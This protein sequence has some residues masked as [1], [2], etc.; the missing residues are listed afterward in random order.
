MKNPEVELRKQLLVS[1]GVLSTAFILGV[2]WMDLRNTHD[3]YSALIGRPVSCESSSPP[4]EPEAFLLLSA[5]NDNVQQSEPNYHEKRRMDALVYQ[6]L[7][8]LENGIPPRAIVL[9]LDDGV[10]KNNRVRNYIQLKTGKLKP[11][12]EIPNDLFI[13]VHADHTDSSLVTASQ[14]LDEEGIYGLVAVVTS[15]PHVQRARYNSCRRG[16][17]GHILSA[18]QILEANDPDTFLQMQKM[19]RLPSYRKAWAIEKVKLLSWLWR[20]NNLDSK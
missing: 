15:E 8:L 13:T 16:V 17:N 9:A 1:I 7:A 20:P 6:Y 19:K 3:V 5:G 10:V 12:T 11:D 14:V 18:D 2:P 4:G